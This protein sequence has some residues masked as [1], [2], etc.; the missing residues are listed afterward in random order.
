MPTPDKLGKIV[1]YLDELLPKKSLDLLI[2]DLVKYCDK[3]NTLYLYYHSA[4][5]HQT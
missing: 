2:S 4:Y 3:P 1:T 5:G